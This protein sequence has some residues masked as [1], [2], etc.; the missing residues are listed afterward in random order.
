MTLL[1]NLTFSLF[2]FSLSIFSVQSQAPASS[3]V[4]KHGQLSIQ[5]GQLA[6]EK[7]QKIQLEGMSL[8]WSQWQ[9][10]F[11]N[12]ETVEY[13]VNYWNIDLI[14][15]A[16]AV[17]HEG[18]LE[19]PAR[20]LKKV[21]KVID[22]AIKKGIYVIVDWHD[23]H[24]QNHLQEAKGFFSEIAKKYGNVPNIIYEPFNEPLNVSWSKVLKP[25]HEAILSEIRRYDPNNIV[26]LGTPEWSQRVDLAAKDPIDDQNVTYALHFYAGTHKEEL[27]KKAE[28]AI[29]MGRPLF[30]TEYGTVL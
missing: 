16:M 2:I 1:K 9:P 23:H 29:D 13:L 22:A 11:Y 27:R 6:D 30:V 20:E 7:G 19:N 25:Y 18:Y 28:K 3:P 15:A 12:E 14:R 5:N 26:V 17:E 21:Q 24:A 4:A 8:F 10:Q